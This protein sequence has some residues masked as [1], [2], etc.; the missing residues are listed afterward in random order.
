MGGLLDNAERINVLVSRAKH[1]LV[2]VGSASTLG[3]L[4]RAGPAE[5]P[6]GMHAA[7]TAAATAAAAGIR[8]RA[9]VGFGAPGEAGPAA[10]LVAFLRSKKWVHPLPAT[11]LA[12]I[13]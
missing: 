9:P 12:D 10:G 7:A 5:V 6:T 8:P 3:A 4:R 1:K 11:A 13:A 2:F